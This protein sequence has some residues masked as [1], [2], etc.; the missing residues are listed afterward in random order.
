MAALRSRCG[1]YILPCG[2][3]LSSCFLS[4]PN[5][6]GRRTGCLPYFHTWCGLS[7]NLECRSEMCRKRLPENTGRKKSLSGHHRT[8]LSGYIFAT[9]ARINNRKK[10]LL[11]R[12]I[13]PTCPYN[14]GNFGLLTAE[15]VS[16]VW[17]T[18][19]SFNG[20]LRLGRVTARNSSGGRQPNFAALNRRHHLHSAGRPSRWTLAHILVCIVPTTSTPKA[21]H[22]VQVLLFSDTS[23]DAVNKNVLSLRLN[24]AVD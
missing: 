24:S 16:L 22:T 14:M 23:C 8:T 15:I 3:F 9:K 2:F 19:P 20:F 5:L 17:G 18:P 13:C 12:N 21:Q 10:H 1:H 4:L 6:S 11:R 7:A